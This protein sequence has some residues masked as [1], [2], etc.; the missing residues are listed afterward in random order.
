[1]P[2]SAWHRFDIHTNHMT[3]TQHFTFQRIL[4]TNTEDYPARTMKYLYHGMLKNDQNSD[5]TN[6]VQCLTSPDLSHFGA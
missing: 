1:M 2:G 6:Q 3:L 5:E 4:G